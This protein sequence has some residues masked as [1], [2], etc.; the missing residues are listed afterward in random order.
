MIRTHSFETSLVIEIAGHSADY[1]ATVKGTY[2]PYSPAYYG[3]GMV[4]IDPPEPASFEIDSCVAKINDKDIDL[5]PLL[6]D[7]Q[8]ETVATEGCQEQY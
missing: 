8:R 1:L 4:A 3:G 5:W 7:K 6:T 2:R